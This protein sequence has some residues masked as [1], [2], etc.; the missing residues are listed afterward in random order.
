MV[1]WWC[2]VAGDVAYVSPAHTSKP[3]MIPKPHAGGGNVATDGASGVGGVMVGHE[4]VVV[5][6]G[7][8]AVVTWCQKAVTWLCW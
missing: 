5:D 6:N 7:G 2:R 3:Y 1:P 4:V 8:G